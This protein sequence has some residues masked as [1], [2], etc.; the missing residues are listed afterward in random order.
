MTRAVKNGRGTYQE[1]LP[2]ARSLLL[3]EFFERECDKF[4]AH[5]LA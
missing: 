5:T 3:G 1:E 2:V 4:V